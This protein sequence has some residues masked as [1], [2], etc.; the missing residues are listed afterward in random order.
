MTEQSDVSDTGEI[1]RPLALVVDDDPDVRELVQLALGHAGFGTAVAQ[2]G[3]EA[4]ATAHQ[5]RPDV[6]VLDVMMP[7]KSG[8]EVCQ[9]LH[10]SVLAHIPVVLLTARAQDEDIDRGFDAGA[11][12]YVVK[13]FSPRALARRLEAVVARA[14]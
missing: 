2:N 14:A 6:I 4:L 8:I 3:D 5:L 7:G 1:Q 13:P 9:Q 12:D 10:Q 11:V